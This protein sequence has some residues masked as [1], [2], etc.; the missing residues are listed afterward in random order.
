[1]EAAGGSEQQNRAGGEA[2]AARAG[3][4]APV[5]MLNLLAFRPDGGRERYQQYSEAVSTLVEGVGGRI[6]WAGAPA[7][8]LIGERAWNLVVLVE[9][10]S[11]VAFL[12]MVGSPEY[13]AIGHLRSEALV[14][15]ELHPMDPV[16]L[17]REND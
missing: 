10:P 1:M 11:R 3:E 17:P 16:P 5:V 9:Y 8:P 14:A 4:D 6:L 13:R 12:E 7:E 15:S 2:F